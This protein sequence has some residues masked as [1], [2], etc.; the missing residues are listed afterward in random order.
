MSESWDIP[1]I[2]PK[3]EETPATVTSQWLHSLDWRLKDAQQQPPT[4]HALTQQQNTHSRR[5]RMRR[6]RTH[7][8]RMRNSRPADRRWELEKVGCWWQSGWARKGKEWSSVF[9]LIEE[10]RVKNVRVC[11]FCFQ[12]KW[13]EKTKVQNMHI[14]TRRGWWR[15][16]KVVG[17][18]YLCA[19]G[20]KSLVWYFGNLYNTYMYAY[21]L[22]RPRP[23]YQARRL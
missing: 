6:S 23:A 5:S 20:F 9:L 12:M 15:G 19:C 4:E 11:L 21:D 13:Y 8:S 16:G 10:W 1:K 3:T 22:N 2:D 14:I 17:K 18:W 7:S